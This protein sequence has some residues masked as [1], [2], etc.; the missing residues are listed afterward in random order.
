MGD[1]RRGYAPQDVRDKTEK[2]EKIVSSERFPGP[3]AYKTR[4]LELGLEEHVRA[5]DKVLDVVSAI[6]AAGGRALLVGGSVR[7]ALFGKVSKDF[8]VEV[9]G[10]EA[11]KIEEIVR[12]HGKVNE[13]GM[14]FG[15][16]KLS[17][18]EDIDVDVSLPRTDSKTGEGHTGFDVK[19]DPNMSIADA[20]LRRDF[21][22]NTV[23]ADPVRG[24]I[25]DA[26]GGVKDIHERRLRVTDREL[27]AD[28]PL[29]ILRGVQFIGRFGLEIDADSFQIMQEMVP[30]LHEI[31]SERFW[32]E[33]K[34]LFLKS[35]KPSLGLSA[36]MSLGV[37]REM[38]PQFVEMR[39]DQQS[40]EHSDV[41]KWI[42][43][44][45]SVDEAA[46]IVRREQLPSKDAFMLMLA[47]MCSNLSRGD[48]S[49]GRASEKPA[50]RNTE[51]AKRFL[52]SIKSDN[53]TRDLVLSLITSRS[54]PGKLYVDDHVR[55][56]VV[57]DGQIR[58]LADQIH[59]ATIE[60]LVLLA[61]AD[62]LGRGVFSTDSRDDLIM[63]ADSFPARDWL[64]ARARELGIESKKAGS[65]IQG[66]DLITAGFKPGT[67]FSRLIALSSDLRDEKRF[68]SGQFFATIDGIKDPGEAIEK[69]ERTLES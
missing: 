21:T 24:T 39:E 26:H 33:W 35:E 3:E 32:E 47:V 48:I 28:D 68:T 16:L 62:H 50:T 36:A 14:A 40:D 29:R 66:R 46:K 6:E 51:A 25:Y 13:V 17:F 54:V 2:D 55:G 45:A 27:F 52:E 65:L 64:L 7:D 10:M 58:R 23:A 12:A 18:G 49:G 30:Q 69:L 44:L 63:P 22:I 20:A 59:P 15:I 5:Y 4:L 9:Y 37:M 31:S 57:T 60:Q 8:D 61:E 67:H 34:K 53:K 1:P 11:G 38:Y 19:T 42:H 56:R 43:T 41:D